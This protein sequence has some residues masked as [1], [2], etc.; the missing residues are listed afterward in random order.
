MNNLEKI[1]KEVLAELNK[2][3]DYR[4][5]FNESIPQ[6]E[7]IVM[8]A[9]ELSIAA[10]QKSSDGVLADRI[11]E[12][13]EENMFL[14]LIAKER[15]QL[16]AVKAFADDIEQFATFS[17]GSGLVRIIYGKDWLALKKKYLKG[18]EG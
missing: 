9:I 7:E 17:D 5:F 16:E 11:H 14:R 15:G 3:W 12:L 4:G 18:V 1:K 13:A 2:H 8:M 10:G 6:A